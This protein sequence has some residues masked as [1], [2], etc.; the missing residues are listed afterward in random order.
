MSAFTHE[1]V[2]DAFAPLIALGFSDPEG[3]FVGTDFHLTLR[4]GDTAIEVVSEDMGTNLPFAHVRQPDG[5]VVDLLDPSA[6]PAFEKRWRLWLPVPWP[7]R[8]RLRKAVRREMELR[9]RRLA[10]A[11]LVE[12]ET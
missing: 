1:L 4:R 3:S 11:A 12:L 7:G 2:R 6:Y 5:A 9:V 8:A 10:Q